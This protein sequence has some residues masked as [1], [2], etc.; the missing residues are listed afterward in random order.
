MKYKEKRVFLVVCSVSVLFYKT[1]NRTAMW[2]KSQKERVIFGRCSVIL[3]LF[4]V[5]RFFFTN[6]RYFV[7]A[8]FWYSFSVLLFL[9]FSIF[10]KKK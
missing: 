2:L 3:F 6:G 4:W 10:S 5:G 1:R 7:Y 9:D 8:L